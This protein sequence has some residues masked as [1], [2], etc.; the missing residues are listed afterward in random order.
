MKKIITLLFTT[1]ILFAFSG[2]VMGQIISQYVETNSGTTP[3]GIEIW[4]NTGSTLDFSTNTLDIL[5]GTN[6]GTPSSDITVTSGTL[7]PGDVMVIGTSDMGTYLTNEGLTSVTFVDKSFTFNGDDALVVEYGGVETDVFGDPGTGDP[8]TGWSGNGVQ[9]Y[10]QNIELNEGITSGS[11]GFTDPS[12]RFSQVGGGTD[13]TGFGIAPP[14][15]DAATK[16]AVT[17]INGGSS[18]TANEGFEV[19][20]QSQDGD[21]NPANVDSDTDVTLTLATGTGSFGGTLTGVISNGSNSVTITG[22]AYDEAESGVS[23]TASDDAL[24]LTSGTSSTFEVLAAADQLIMKDF[25]SSGIAGTAV[26]SFTVEAQ[27]SSDNSVDL[28]YSEDITISKVSGSGTISGTLTKT[29]TNGVATFDD[30]QF[31][32]DDDYT[33]SAT[34][35]T[36]TSS[37]SSTLTISTPDFVE[38]FETENFNVTGSYGDGS[39][40][41]VT[42]VSWTYVE[43]RNDG[44]YPING[45]NAIMLRHSS[46]NSSLTSNVISG[47]IEEFSVLFRKAFTGSGNRQLELFIGSDAEN[48]ESY[49]TSDAFDVDG[50][51]RKF[52]VSDI[53]Y[54]GDFVIRISNVTSSQVNI[55]NIS[56]DSFND[57]EMQI[58]GNAGWRMLSFPITGGTVADI[59]DDTAIQGITGGDNTGDDPTFQIFNSGTTTTDFST[60]ADVSTPFG[61]G[62]GFITYFYNNTTAGSSVLPLTL[63]ASGTEPASDVTV[64]LNTTGDFTLVGNPFA[65]NFDLSTISTSTGSIQTNV[66]F[67]D[68]SASSGTGSYIAVDRTSNIT[69]P[70]Q[71]FWVESTDADDI[72]FPTSGKTTTA[73]DVSYSKQ[74]N[75]NADIAFTLSSEE[76]FD[77]AI[78]MSFRENAIVGWDINDASKFTPLT[79][80]FATMAFV[81][82]DNLQS[83]FSLPTDL[84]EEVEV[85][86]QETMVGVSGEFTFA[87]DGMA[88]LPSGLSLTLHDYE[89]GESVNMRDIDSYTFEVAESQAKE[90]PVSAM[91][92][93]ANM[94]AKTDE[95]PRFGIIAKSNTA[96]SNEEDSQ[97]ERF[98][99]KQNYPNPFNPTTSIQYSVENAGEVSLTV[100]NVMGQQVATLV[101]ESKSAGT[102]QITWD[103]SNNASGIYY[104]RLQS[105]G[106]VLTR[107]MTLIK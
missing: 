79:N 40:E 10:N 36:L 35:G 91:S 73:A 41:G 27:R 71:G 85:K 67:W 53:N 64:T 24:G 92:V 15:G 72:T 78:R 87:W 34:D 21:S 56:W 32:T 26:S 63:G 81:G 70:W 13:L 58:T 5:K 62:F 83:V 39:F 12:T 69:A 80:K 43:S 11:T 82:E 74:N 105:A 101:S 50:E 28:A 20:I 46:G 65:S 57:G 6:G 77:E 45:D 1:L 19:V 107:Q 61:D 52:T 93:Q 60:P 30:I 95:A 89:T 47:G 25:P 42:G 9:T 8:G 59:S 49:G 18:P 96:V 2:S 4:N 14:S 22:V 23:I 97:P 37:T 99:L 7:D 17:Q 48:L 33:I 100:Y 102:Y 16:L 106:Q 66:Q 68:A 29:A 103:A 3:K 54:V 55:D 38:T 84:E 94:M 88:D 90:S 75:V 98:T 44:G 86:L 31:D 51:V 104:Y 76:T